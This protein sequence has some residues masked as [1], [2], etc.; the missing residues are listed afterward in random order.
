MT[1]LKQYLLWSLFLLFGISKTYQALL[2]FL[3]NKISIHLF[4]KQNKKRN[5]QHFQL[6]FFLLNKISVRINFSIKIIFSVYKL[7]H[8]LFLPFRDTVDCD[9]EFLNR[10]KIAWLSEEKWVAQSDSAVAVA[11]TPDSRLSRLP[12][13]HIHYAP[14]LCPAPWLTPQHPGSATNTLLHLPIVT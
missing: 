12:S 1:D 9:C 5:K 11:T 2:K 6:F 8:S 7:A 10:Q 14:L 13:P 4:T 3:A